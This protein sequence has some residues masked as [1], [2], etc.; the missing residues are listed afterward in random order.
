MI[1]ACHG[2]SVMSL[3]WPPWIR[4]AGMFNELSV[5]WP[6]VAS[7]EGKQEREERHREGEGGARRRGEGGAQG[8]RETEGGK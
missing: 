3:S 4:N 2:C 7:G 1:T 6:Q 5:R 8:Q